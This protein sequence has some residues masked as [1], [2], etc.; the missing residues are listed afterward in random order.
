MDCRRLGSPLEGTELVFAAEPGDDPV[1]RTVKPGSDEFAELWIEALGLGLGTNR[2][3]QTE[4]G[5]SGMK[6]AG[7]FAREI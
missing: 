5:F 6:A 3:E 1:N 4:R 2:P 7:C